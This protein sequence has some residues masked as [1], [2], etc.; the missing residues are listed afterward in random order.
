MVQDMEL[1]TNFLTQSEVMQ[2]SSTMLI[3][4]QWLLNPSSIAKGLPELQNDW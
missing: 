3:L 4:Y 1:L 2:I